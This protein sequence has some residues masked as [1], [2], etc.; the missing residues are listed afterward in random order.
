[1][2][3]VSF[4]F[5]D[6][7][8]YESVQNYAKKLMENGIEVHI[9]T[10]RYENS[11]DYLPVIWPNGHNDMFNIAK[12]L[13][14]KTENIH[15]TNFTDKW[16]F[17]KD[18]PDFIWHLDDNNTETYLISGHDLKTKAVLFD[19]NYQFYCNKLLNIELE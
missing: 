9:V 1:M 15:F 12:K 16:Q 10:S 3:K 13:G 18:N 6:T 8:E 19:G 11:D 17:F 7:L 4:D 14:I 5:D 2:K